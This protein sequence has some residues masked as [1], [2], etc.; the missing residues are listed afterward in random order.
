VFSQLHVQPSDS[1]EDAG[2]SDAMAGDP[3]ELHGLLDVTQRVTVLAKADKRASERL[4]AGPLD[5]AGRA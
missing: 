3:E 5:P 1:V 2:L 4:V